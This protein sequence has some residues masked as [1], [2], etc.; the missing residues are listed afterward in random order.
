MPISNEALVM[1]WKVLVVSFLPVS[2]LLSPG[3]RLAATLLKRCRHHI[4]SDL[5][6][7]HPLLQKEGETQCNLEE[8]RLSV[9]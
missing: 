4:A 2:W 5:D 3:G 6:R 1:L 8:T 7:V 9:H